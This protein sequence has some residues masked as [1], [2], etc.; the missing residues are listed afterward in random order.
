MALDAL[1]HV[2]L[3]ARDL[4]RSVRFY[5]DVLGLKSGARPPFNFP[6]AWLYLGDRPVVHLIGGRGATEGTGAIDHVAFRATGL[7][8]TRGRL[9]KLGHSIDERTVPGQGLHQVF[10]RD[11]DGVKI[12]LNFAAAEAKA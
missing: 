6:G 10:L 2:T 1:D 3:V 4:D 9:T 5:E 12:E 11:P 8:A 7:A